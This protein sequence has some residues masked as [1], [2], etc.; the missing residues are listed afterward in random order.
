MYC[1][2]DVIE[3]L[4]SSTGG[5]ALDGEHRALRQ[6][7][8]HAYRDLV[9]IRD[10]KWHHTTEIVPISDADLIVT[11]RLPWGVTSVDAVYLP[12]LR[13]S[14]EYV[15]QTEWKRI[16]TSTNQQLVRLAWTVM[17]PS[18][19]G[20]RYE[21]K[22]YN[23]YRYNEDLTLTYRRRPRDIRYTGWESNSRIGTVTMSPAG[24]GSSESTVAGTGTQFNQHMVGS[25]FR[26]SGSSTNHPEGLTG[27]HP[28]LVE[29]VVTS[30]NS[31]TS[32]DIVIPEEVAN[33]TGTKYIVTDYL[34]ISPTMYTALLSGSEVWLARLLGKNI[35]GAMGVNARDLRLAFEQ[36]TTAPMDGRRLSTGGRYTFWYLRAGTDQG[37]TP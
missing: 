23:G 25:V 4:M 2:Y 7:L 36:D 8:F 22:I 10:W 30:V 6:A 18:E 9:S 5:G 1:A 37:V 28:Y 34:D 31:S 29:G 24:L 27:M 26:A 15:A 3:Y 16:E 12:Q 35:E 33:Y 21:L 13:I 32:M 17:P 20:D 19:P 11:H 14:A